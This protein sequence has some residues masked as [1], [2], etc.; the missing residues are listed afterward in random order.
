MPGVWGSLASL[1][2]APAAVEFSHRLFSQAYILPALPPRRLF[3]STYKSL[4]LRRPSVHPKSLIPA[5]PTS[6]FCLC[7]PSTGSFPVTNFA[8]KTW[9]MLRLITRGGPALC[10]V[11]VTNACNAAC[12]CH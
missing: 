6:G 10:N 1:S 8:S 5:A 3:S 4:R 2:F 9:D 7:S 11:A 12:A